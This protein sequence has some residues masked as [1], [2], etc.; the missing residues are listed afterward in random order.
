MF[1]SVAHQRLLYKFR[2]MGI[3]GT[4]IKW[5]EDFLVRRY[6]IACVEQQQSTIVVIENGVP[7]G[8]VLG[9]TV[10]LLFIKDCE[11]ELDCDCAIFADDIKIWVVIHN[12]ADE[13]DSHENLRLVDE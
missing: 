3:G 9:P 2:V 13:T 4:L 6:Q 7:Q 5:I 12:A 11:E 1:D 8:S 10:F